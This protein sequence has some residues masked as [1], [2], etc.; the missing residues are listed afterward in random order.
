MSN[1]VTIRGSVYEEAV[2]WAKE[3][4]PNYVTNEMHQ[5]GYYTYNP[6]YFDFFFSQDAPEEMTLFALRW[7]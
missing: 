1:Y 3:N 6:R 2:A 5:D 7:A 4:C